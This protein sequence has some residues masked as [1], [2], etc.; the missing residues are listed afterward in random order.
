MSAQ[1][2]RAACPRDSPDTCALLVTVE[3]GRATRVQ[4]DFMHPTTH[5]VLCT[6]VVCGENV[7]VA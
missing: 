1:V 7:S 6:K 3:G 4:G 5:R 2:I